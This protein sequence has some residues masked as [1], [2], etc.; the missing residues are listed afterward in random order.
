M[1]ELVTFLERE[2]MKSLEDRRQIIVSNII[3]YI[4]DL[5]LTNFV[6]CFTSHIITRYRLV[7]EYTI[8]TRMILYEKINR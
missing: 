1:I 4:I 5:L 7:I 2:R 3:K 6:K 8:M